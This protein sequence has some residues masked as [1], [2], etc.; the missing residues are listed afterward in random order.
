MRVFVAGATGAI[1]RRLVPMLVGEGHDVVAI[2]RRPERLEALAGLGAQGEVADALDRDAVRAVVERTRPEVIVHE[3]TDLPA[4]LKPQKLKQAYAANNRV[5]REGTANLLAAAEAAGVG[6]IVAQSSAFWY[7][8]T[9]GPVKSEDEPLDV[10]A[11]EPIGEAVR[12]MAEAERLMQS[13]EGIDAVILRYGIFYGPG[14]WYHPEGDIG[15]QVVKRRYPIIGRG[16]GITSFVHIDDAARATT[17]ALAAPPGVY[18]VVDDHPA[19]VSEWLPAL[20]QALDAKPPMRAPAGVARL[21]AGKVAFDWLEHQRGASNLRAKEQLGWQPTY[22][23]WR[24][25]FRDGMDAE[26]P[27]P[28]PR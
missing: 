14:T 18:N 7:A 24:T 25:G 15:R 11:G 17:L 3:L 19:P 28:T 20:A 23:D 16:S 2:T 22:P 13:A 27:Q 8:P 4:A 12:T 9:G 5:R 10:D 26:P 1:G 6:R 21:L